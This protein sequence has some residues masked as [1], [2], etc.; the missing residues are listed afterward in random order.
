MMEKTIYDSFHEAA[1]GSLAAMRELRELGLLAGDLHGLCEAVTF[2]RLAAAR[3]D[4]SDEAQLVGILAAFAEQKTIAPHIYA[5][6]ALARVERL[7]DL[8]D[9]HAEATSLNVQAL[10]DEPTL[11]HARDVYNAL[12]AIGKRGGK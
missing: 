4:A 11:G 7:A 9:E 2:A 3:G 8:G 12:K 5:G 6:E 10:A 1:H